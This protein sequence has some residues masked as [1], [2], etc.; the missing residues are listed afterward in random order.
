MVDEPYSWWPD[1][2]FARTM[3]ASRYMLTT[4]R[5]PRAHVV[6]QFFY[7]KYNG[8]W[9]TLPASY[10]KEDR[11]KK[12]GQPPQLQEP[13]QAAAAGCGHAPQPQAAATGRSRWQR[14]PAMRRGVQ[15][16]LGHRVPAAIGHSFFTFTVAAE[17]SVH[18]CAW[19]ASHPPAPYSESHNNKPPL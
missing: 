8:G 7:L 14:L 16:R 11:R 4:L 19:H 13:S 10:R 9:C 18:L 1:E 17:A 5:S 12:L 2:D 3:V 15:E 6:S